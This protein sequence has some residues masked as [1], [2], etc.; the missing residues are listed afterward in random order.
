MPLGFRVPYHLSLCLFYLH[1]ATM[2]P[3]L[4]SPG[5]P[6][7][8]W[9]LFAFPTLAGCVALTLLPAARK[10]PAYVLKD[11]TPWRWPLY[12][13]CLFVFIALGVCARSATHCL[14]VNYSGGTNG[15]EG[16]NATIFGPYFLVPFGFAV[17]ALLL[18]IGI[19]SR[20]RA[21]VRIGLLAPLVLVG[22]AAIGHRPDPAYQRFLRQFVD[23]AASTPMFA[24]LILAIAFYAVAAWR[25]VRGAVDLMTA[26]VAA[27]SFISPGT[28]DF[29]GL[30]LPQAPP[31]LAAC[32]IQVYLG[33]TRGSLGRGLIALATLSAATAVGPIG[34]WSLP[35]RAV[36]ASYVAILGLMVIG[37]V[38]RDKLARVLRA[39]AALGLAVTCASCLWASASL[40]IA[41]VAT[42]LSVL[43]AVI[44]GRI[45]GDRAFFVAAAF[46]LFC[47]AGRYGSLAYASLRSL[48]P[49][50]DQIAI[51][52][53][54]FVIAAVI[55][56]AKAGALE[57]LLQRYRRKP[58]RLADEP[59]G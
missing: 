22:L 15:Y 7:L 8:A 46:A 35:G 2:A 27:M 52:L 28:F 30:T 38:R 4:R 54:F 43:A 12:P 29:D 16:V 39:V 23:A 49:G 14:S 57:S 56:L 42:L 24:T 41:Q 44:Y 36:A 19:T 6:T 31:L 11:G 9:G 26:S 18:E 48:I 21:T 47:W 3:W 13:W 59:A 40:E 33:V 1:P 51:G 32:L 45:V 10:G 5:D 17:A 20:H 34:D 58:A 25:G 55:S 37:A 53:V 50:L